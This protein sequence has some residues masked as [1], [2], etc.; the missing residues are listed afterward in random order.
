MLDFLACQSAEK[1]VV[2]AESIAMVKRLLQG[3]EVQTDPLAT[4]FYDDFH[5][6]SDFLKQRLTRQL[7]PKEQVLPSMVIDR[8]S[9]RVWEEQGKTDAFQR[10]RRRVKELLANYRR[11]PMKEEE[12]AALLSLVSQ[13]AREAGLDTL[14]PLI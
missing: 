3:I 6:K 12:E 2:D 8:G 14:P 1:L 7:F 9:I 4:R 11:P 10:A 5:F 13:V